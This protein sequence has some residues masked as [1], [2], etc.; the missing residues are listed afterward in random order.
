MPFSTITN[1]WLDGLKRKSRGKNYGDTIK[2]SVNKKNLNH[3]KYKP[4]VLTVANNMKVDDENLKC[5]I[6]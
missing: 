4:Q 3:D 5:E 2:Y 6:G 1:G